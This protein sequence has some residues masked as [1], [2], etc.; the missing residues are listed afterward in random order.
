MAAK[1]MADQIVAAN[2]QRQNAKRAWK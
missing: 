2:L 1:L